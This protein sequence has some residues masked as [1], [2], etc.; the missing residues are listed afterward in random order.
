MYCSSKQHRVARFFSELLRQSG[1]KQKLPVKMRFFHSDPHK[2]STKRVL[3][4][5]L[6]KKILGPQF[7]FFYFFF[8]T[9]FF[10]RK[11]VMTLTL[12]RKISQKILP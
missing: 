6:A 9:N 4:A 5:F 11:T 2:K 10:F 7:L 3:R 1:E 8:L 12:R